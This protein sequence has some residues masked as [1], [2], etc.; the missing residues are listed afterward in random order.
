MPLLVKRAYIAVFHDIVMAAASFTLALYL[1]LGDRF[2]QSYDYLL[3]GTLVFTGVCALVFTG[4]RLYQGMWRYA[5]VPDLVAITKAVTLAILIFLPAMFMVNRLE[6]VPRSM[7]VINWM[8]LIL[9]LGAPRFLY[10]VVKD[11]RL[12]LDFNSSAV[13]KRIPVLLVGLNDAAEL[14]LRE[15]SRHQGEY[16]VVG[17]VDEDL[18]RIGRMIHG[19]RVY[20][21]AVELEAV[22]KKLRQIGKSP[23]KIVIAEN[24][25][26]KTI[27]ERLL[28]TADNLGLTVAKLPTRS[29][30]KGTDEAV[31]IRPIA[32]ED[33]LGRPQTAL[34][35][36][37]MRSFIEGKTV[38]VTGA[39]GTIGGELVR[40]IAASQPAYLVL[41]ELCEYNLYAIELELATAFPELS[42]RAVI[43]DVRDVRQLDHCF[44]RCK[45]DVVFHAAALKHVPMAEANPLE[46]LHTNTIGSQYVA[47]ACIAHQVANM[48]MISTDKA[49]N[50][51]N[52]MGATKRIAES[53][54]QAL[55]GAEHNQVTT[56]TTVRFGNVLGSSGSVI[57]LFQKQ[58]AAGG[59]LTVTHPDMERYF[60]TVREAVELVLQAAVLGDARDDKSAIFVL[61]MGEPVK[62]V[63][64]AT[65]MIRMAGLRPHE[66]IAITYTGLRPGEKLYEELFYGSEALEDTGTAGIMLAKPDCLSYEQLNKKYAIFHQIIAE[67]DP[68]KVRLL[69]KDA[70]PEYHLPQQPNH[71]DNATDDQRQP[72]A[73]YA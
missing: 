66:D 35:R 42:Y 16:R 56:F 50:P 57:P 55:G 5:S 39:G 2:S 10:R 11:R 37:A 65:Q 26:D 14:F 13:D 51:M 62:I 49:V 45:P 52:V 64:L 63:D 60:M 34:N 22:V 32:I 72:E 54:C 3:E 19:V 1:R 71:E 20:G 67:H 23:Q 58:L 46:T 44:A 33:L 48:V 43:G 6:G 25:P 28:A 41:Y 7:L 36:P 73:R 38:L 21:K 24:H 53:Y 27:V 47:D 59:P 29:E 17:I 40:Q 18:S 9:M 31:A 70:V 15:V 8:L 30:L 4:M 68:S 61:D 12:N 69:L